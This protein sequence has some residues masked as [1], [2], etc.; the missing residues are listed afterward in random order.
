MRRETQ[1]SRERGCSLCIAD[2]DEDSAKE[3]IST[4]PCGYLGLRRSDSPMQICHNGWK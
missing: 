1:V 2:A 4:A 3:I